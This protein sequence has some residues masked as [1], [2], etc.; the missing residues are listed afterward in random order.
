[1]TFDPLSDA[2]W[3]RGPGESGRAEPSSDRRGTTK[4]RPRGGLGWKPLSRRS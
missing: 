1:M 3:N 4:T 2:H